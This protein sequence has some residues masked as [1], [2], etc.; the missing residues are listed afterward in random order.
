GFSSL[1]VRGDGRAAGAEPVDTADPAIAVLGVPGDRLRD[2]LFPGNLGLPSRLAV[3]LLVADA[4]RHD[5]A[6]PRTHAQRRRHDLAVAP[7]PL[8]AADAQDELRPVT[9]RDVL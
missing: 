2:A 7:V 8:L 3:Q 4:Q 5:L 6:R 9:H 1:R